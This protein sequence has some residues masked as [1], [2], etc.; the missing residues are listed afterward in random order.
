MSS[1]PLFLQ[2]LA[3]GLIYSL[4]LA[5]SFLLLARINPE[6]WLNDYPP[7]IKA[8]FGPMSS[9]ANRVRQIFGIPIIIFMLGFPFFVIFQFIQI[10]PLTFWQVFS[11]LL[12][13]YTFFNLFDL[14]VMDWLIFNTIQPRFMI[15]P[16][17]EGM[18][19]YKDYGFHFR[20]SLKGQ[21]GLTLFSLIG[22]GILMLFI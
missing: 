1:L 4:T 18:A 7:D 9:K 3:Y 22:A 14:L 16:G 12:T 6:A 10:N 20:A 11:I 19:G 8:K 21:M 15:L 2:S 5:G 13:L 17:T